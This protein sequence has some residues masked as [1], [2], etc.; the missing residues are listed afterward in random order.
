[1]FAFVWHTSYTNHQLDYLF[2]R[3]KKINMHACSKP[4]TFNTNIL[5]IAAIQKKNKWCKKLHCPTSQFHKRSNHCS[6]NKLKIWSTCL[7]STKTPWY[8]L[9]ASGRSRYRSLSRL[10]N[11][12]GAWLVPISYRQFQTGNRLSLHDHVI[13]D[14][15]VASMQVFFSKLY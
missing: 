4:P 2:E 15:G 6:H 5:W 12:A 7:Q 1:M 3:E 13:T 14:Q 9:K 11:L 10:V 8:L